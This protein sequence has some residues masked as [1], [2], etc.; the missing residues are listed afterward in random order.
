MEQARNRTAEIIKVSATGVGVN[1]L[2]V[3]GKGLIGF[4]TRSIAVVL[5]ALNNLSDALSSG[6]TIVGAK[7]AG[8]AAD[9]EHPYGHGRVEYISSSVI[10]L[11]VL[12]AGFSSLRS[13]VKQILSPG[14]IHHTALSAA[15]LGV[16][17]AVKIFLGLY[18]KRQGKRLHSSSL[19]ASGTDALFDAVIGA[20]TLVSALLNMILHRNL[21]GF[22]GLIISL[23]ILKAG[24]DILRDT[25][26]SIIGLRPDAELVKNVKALICEDESI[27]GA[28]DLMLHSYGPE[29]WFGSVHVEVDDEMTVRELDALTRRI[30]PKVYETYGVLLT[31]GVYATNTYDRSAQSMKSAVLEAV[32]P[33]PQIL[34]THGFY[35]DETAKTVSFDV[36]FDFK[37]EHCVHIVEEIRNRLLKR[38]P[39]HVFSIQIDRDVSD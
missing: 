17:V 38:Y 6:V 7:L 3:L 34:Q 11:L 35:Y 20:G 4:F 2:L 10:A 1:L 24:V 31:I 9:R 18:F 25:V 5:D 21:E 33:Y 16:G 23:L 14:E 8:K 29:V 13:S 27:H 12:L 15:L 28:Y 19:S 30:V 26:N 22:L 36:I 39:D 32:S 37:T